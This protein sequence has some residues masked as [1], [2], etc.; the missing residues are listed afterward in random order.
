[1]DPEEGE[2][3]PPRRSRRIQ[4][5]SPP[6]AMPP[7][8][9]SNYNTAL[10]HQDTPGDGTTTIASSVFIPPF[11]QANEERS[12][13][14]PEDIP[15]PPS[16]TSTQPSTHTYPVDPLPT[17]NQLPLPNNVHVPSTQYHT[18]F[19]LAPAQN[20]LSSESSIT[21]HQQYVAVNEF[22]NLQHTVN[23]LQNNI[24]QVTQSLATINSRTNQLQTSIETVNNNLQANITQA[25]IVAMSQFQPM[26]KHTTA[27]NNNTT[28]PSASAYDRTIPTSNVASTSFQS[29]HNPS[30]ISHHQSS[31]HSQNQHNTNL[32][33]N[34]NTHS[35]STPS[36]TIAELINI[37]SNP[38]CSF[39]TF[40]KSQNVYEWKSMCILEL[41]ASTKPIHANMIC[42]NAHGDPQLN[43]NLTRTESQELFCLTKSGL[44]TKLN[45]KF[46]T[47]DVLRRADGIELWEMIIARFKPIAKDEI[48]IT[49]M[50]SSFTN[51]K[52]QPRETDDAYSWRNP[53]LPHGSFLRSWY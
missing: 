26:P 16:Q 2:S 52:R 4:Q 32:K 7:E 53:N 46:I 49:D 35:Q 3:I 24:A 19:Q 11:T 9:T 18:P 27:I 6:T 36:L 50:T 30:P 41:A 47:V 48:E 12:I 14:P 42:Y 37:S 17:H 20:Q 15:Q 21:S 25:V 8:S 13:D 45:T 28:P 29:T 10:N 31:E 44:S 5:L 51:F 33:N 34:N 39:P 22:T 40:T 38:K 23:L 43:Q 1:M